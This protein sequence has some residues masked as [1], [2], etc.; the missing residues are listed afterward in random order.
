MNHNIQQGVKTQLQT[1]VVLFHLYVLCLCRITGLFHE[2]GG[3]IIRK[4]FYIQCPP[5]QI[6]AVPKKLANC[7]I[8]PVGE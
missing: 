5:L 3:I 6:A 2:A 8:V 4:K 7:T 1:A